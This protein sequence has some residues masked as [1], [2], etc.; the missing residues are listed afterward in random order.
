MS[1]LTGTEKRRESGIRERKRWVF[2]ERK[3][4]FT[5]TETDVERKDELCFTLDTNTSERESGRDSRRFLD[6][7]WN[8]DAEVV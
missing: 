6:Y 4:W 5:R 3:G 7:P 2:R 8:N 1:S